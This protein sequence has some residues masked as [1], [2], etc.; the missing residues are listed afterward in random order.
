VGATDGGWRVTDYKTDVDL[1]NGDAQRRYDEL[2][3]WYA[4]AW[5][6]VAGGAVAAAIVPARKPRASEVAGES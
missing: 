6:R 5:G 3:R 1:G 4:A 2:V